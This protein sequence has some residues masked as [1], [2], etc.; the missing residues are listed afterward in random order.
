MKESESC[1]RARDWYTH[2]V[3]EAAH[4]KEEGAKS[5]LGFWTGLQE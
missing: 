2:K 1:G 4:G 5:S 3:V